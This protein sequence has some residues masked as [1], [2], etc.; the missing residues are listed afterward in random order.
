LTRSP[1]LS[2]PAA[3]LN[4]YETILTY[5]GSARAF[6]RNAICWKLPDPAGQPLATVRDIRDIRDTIAQQGRALIDELLPATNTA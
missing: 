5:A 4:K 1:E 2:S 3:E 6:K